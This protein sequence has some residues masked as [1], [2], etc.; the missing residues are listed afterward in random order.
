M[1]SRVA[2]S[3]IEVMLLAVLALPLQLAAQN[4]RYK[5][6][7]M[8]TFGG[9]NSFFFSS[10]VVESVNNRGVVAGGADTG[11]PDPYA[12]DCFSPDC[13]ILHAF[14]WK[15]GVLTD[16]GTLPGGYS[17][18]AYWINDRALII[19]GS[20]NGLIDPITGLPEQIAV[21]WERDGEIIN[22]GTLGGS[23]SFANAMNNRGHVVGIAL[24]TVPDPYSFLGLGTE[25]H[26]FVWR[27]GFMEDL[28]TLGGPDSWGSAVNENGKVVGW[29]YINSMPNQSNGD[30][31]APNV[32]TQDPF[33]WEDG[34]MIDLGT[35]GG[36]CGVVGSFANAGSGGAINSRGQVV[37][38][39]N[40]AGN[41][42]HHAFL[43]DQGS[44]TDLGTLGGDN[45]EAYWIN[46]AG[47]IVGRADVP[48]PQQHHHGF[49][50]RN[51]VMADL[52][53]PAGQSC[54]T[55]IDINARSQIIL[56]TG[57][58]GVGGGPGSLWEDGILYDLNA[59]IPRDSGFFIGDVNFINDR[60]EIAVTGVLP[61]GDQHDLLLIPVDKG[62]DRAEEIAD[63]N[64]LS[65]SQP[66]STTV[67][68]VVDNS[69][70]YVS[71]SGNRARNMFRQT[72]QLP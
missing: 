50:W 5:L 27:D 11:L 1:K 49:R 55:A 61:N 60:G 40:L 19:G 15:S 64:A 52:G 54:S 9:P 71:S 35:F 51:G 62:D 39:S 26:A 72:R 59:L 18:T 45:A 68:T 8:G 41:Q 32:P 31:C 42:T 37:G 22:L 16:L 48:G 58:C 34:R 10:P 21:L 56:D 17:S 46:D 29:A 25:T 24:N 2:K 70:N 3:M 30:T 43:W 69:E 38:S 28:G 14:K 67:H 47:D 6:V 33:L 44:L 20:Q 7:D 63:V 36:T 66:R 4:T 57:I 23:F 12:P 65:V 13:Y 53:V